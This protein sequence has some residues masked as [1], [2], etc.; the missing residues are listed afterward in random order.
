MNHP[1][2][3]LMDR[4]VYFNDLPFDARVL[5]M[6][7]IVGFGAVVA[8]AAGHLIEQSSWLILLVKISMAI[9]IAILFYMTNRFKLYVQGRWLTVIVFCDILFPFIYFF[10]G[11]VHSGITAY[12]ALC[13]VIVVLLTRGMLL[14]VIMITFLCV[15][16][17][18]YY[19]DYRFPDVVIPITRLQWYLDSCISFIITGIF[20]GLVIKILSKMYLIEKSKADE[21]SRAKG[22]FLSQMS[23][24]MR[25]PMNAVIGMASIAKSENTIEKY[26][27]CMDQI[28][29]ASKHLLG[30][31]NDI[32]DMSKIE[33]GK[34]ELAENDFNIR[35]AISDVESIIGFQAASK[36]QDLTVDIA[37]DVPKYLYGD[38]QHLS[39][40]LTNLLSNAVKFTPEN[41]AVK[42]TLQL[43]PAFKV[44]SGKDQVPLLMRVKDTGIGISSEQQARLFQPFEQADNSTSRL[45]G[46]TGLGLVISKRIAE[47]MHG[48]ITI[49]S[50]LGEGA[51]FTVR[52]VFKR[53]KALPERPSPPPA[54]SQYNFA[55]RRIL[56]AEDV[57]INREIFV[58]LV[59]PTGLQ[60]DC[61][62]NGR[63]AVEHYAADPGRYDMIFMDLRMPEMDGYEAVRRIRALPDPQ[64]KKIPIL[65]VTANVFREDIERSLAA[66]MN[67]HIGKP[68]VPED[69]FQQIGRYLS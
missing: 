21:A 42:L 14:W 49:D 69:V 19:I 6:V 15:A 36:N 22:N 18:C 59:E 53:G 34:L 13:M 46:G 26:Q 7:C 1:I 25:T 37:D 24:E 45:Y 30:V 27:Y 44:E 4:Y 48:S 9:A 31:I 40:I 23:H 41:G 32:L 10:N 55:G 54:R 33:T 17:F 39:L 16:S 62:T 68:L 61:V 12:F 52:V 65:A 47:M 56:L 43:D 50:D 38:A 5:N 29:V 20:I 57:E 67:G 60:I 11:G 58:S 66:G 51:V 35:R 2:R 3:K 28:E 63:E 64:A 8:S